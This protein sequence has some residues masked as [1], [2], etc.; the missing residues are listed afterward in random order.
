MNIILYCSLLIVLIIGMVLSRPAM[1]K[2]VIKNHEWEVPNEPG[3]EEVITEAVMAQE[4]FFRR[5]AT[6]REC[7][8]FPKELRAIFSRYE[9]S[10]KYLES[11]TGVAEALTG[12]I[13]K[14]G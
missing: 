6:I 10:R 4:R 11:N 2:I 5:C 9:V 12:S 13:F 7:R 8:Q 3:W 14:W 1:Q